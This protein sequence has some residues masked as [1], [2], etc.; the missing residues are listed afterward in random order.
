MTAF[1]PLRLA[2]LA[3]SAAALSACASI[4]REDDIVDRTGGG[5]ECP[6]EQYQMLVGQPGA[7]IEAATLPQPAR[8]YGPG[9]A[10][11]MDYRT[12]RLNVEIGDDGA[13]KRVYCG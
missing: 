7:D 6:A 2:V 5:R 1:S 9:D 3:G 12:D 10:I 13:V 11:T 8:V 4:D